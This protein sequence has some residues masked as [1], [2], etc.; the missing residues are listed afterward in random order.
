MQDYGAMAIAQAKAEFNRE[1]LERRSN[2]AMK[3]L[4]RITQE[5]IDYQAA[6]AEQIKVIE[7]TGLGLCDEQEGL[8]NL[9][10]ALRDLVDPVQGFPQGEA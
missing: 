2:D 7:G 6:L 4:E 10:G 5:I 3:D 1:H 8:L 9:L